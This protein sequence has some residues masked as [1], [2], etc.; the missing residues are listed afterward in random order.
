MK[1]A[2]GHGSNG[3]DVH[4]EARTYHKENGGRWDIQQRN[5]RYNGQS[6]Q[7]AINFGLKKIGAEFPDHDEHYAE[8]TDNPPHGSQRYIPDNA[9]AAR[10]LASGPKSNPV[11]VRDGMKTP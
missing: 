11:P 4:A 7:A 2:L 8:I 3:H 10:E 9:A 5:Y 1:D 6:R